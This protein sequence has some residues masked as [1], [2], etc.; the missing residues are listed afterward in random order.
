[1]TVRNISRISKRPSGRR[2]NCFRQCR[3]QAM[4]LKNNLPGW[5]KCCAASCRLS[6]PAH[7]SSTYSPKIY[8]RLQRH[9][10]IA[11]YNATSNSLSANKRCRRA[12]TIYE[13]DKFGI[14][15]R[16]FIHADVVKVDWEDELTKALERK[17]PDSGTEGFLSRP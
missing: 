2:T 9:K 16:H 10:G 3:R 11:A 15:G 17:T 8:E 6:L 7:D 1:M 12:H 5:T 13:R 4:Y 14:S